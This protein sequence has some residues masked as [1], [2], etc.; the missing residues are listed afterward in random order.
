MIKKCNHAKLVVAIPLATWRW[1]HTWRVE[2]LLCKSIK[3]CQP[4]LQ[5]LK[6]II[7]TLPSSLTIVEELP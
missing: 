3:D 5:D 2:N 6:A 4:S 7:A 1:V